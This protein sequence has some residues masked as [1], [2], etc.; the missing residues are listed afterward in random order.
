MGHCSLTF[1]SDRM[2][3]MPCLLN[4][5]GLS[6]PGMVACRFVLR[7]A[8]LVPLTVIVWLHFQMLVTRCSLQNMSTVDWLS[9]SV[10]RRMFTPWNMC[11]LTKVLWSIVTDLVGCLETSALSVSTPVVLQLMV[12]LMDPSS[13]SEVAESSSL[14]CS[15]RAFN[16]SDKVVN[17]LATC[18]CSL[19][20]CLVDTPSEL[21]VEVEFLPELLD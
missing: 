4:Q 8:P 11:L 6:Y 17:Y 12:K 14:F 21:E 2:L 1:L 9:R 20:N 19:L 18:F 3:V 5:T 10:A 7:G 15:W 16:L 13:S